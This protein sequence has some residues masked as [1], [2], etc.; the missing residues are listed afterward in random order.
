M[1]R[2]PGG[3]GFAQQRLRWATNAPRIAAELQSVS[4]Q[5]VRCDKQRQHRF[6][7]PVSSKARASKICYTILKGF[8]S[9]LQRDNRI[10]GGDIGSVCC[11]EPVLAGNDLDDAP[12]I[13][14]ESWH[15]PSDSGHSDGQPSRQYWDDITGEQLDSSLVEQAIAEEMDTYAKHGVYRKV[16]IGDC[17]A[18]TGKAPIKVRWVITNKGDRQSPDYCSWQ[19]RSWPREPRWG[20]SPYRIPDPGCNNS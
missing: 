3:N 14:C 20:H 12:T 10:H 18:Q 4:D 2:S 5:S 16:P 8:R 15:G 9:Q 11:E 17:Y 19:L 1:V 7:R 6:G 13:L